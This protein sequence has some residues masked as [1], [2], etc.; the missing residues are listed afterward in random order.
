[1]VGKDFVIDDVVAVVVAP[2]TFYEKAEDVF[3]G[4]LVA[5]EGGLGQMQAA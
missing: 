2:L 4:L 3:Y 1:M 5:F